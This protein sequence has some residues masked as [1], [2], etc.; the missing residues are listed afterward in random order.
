M[1]LF[2]IEIPCSLSTNPQN[3]HLQKHYC[4]YSYLPNKIPILLLSDLVAVSI[5]QE[6]NLLP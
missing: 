5:P 6:I 1:S 3:P 4:Q 2:L